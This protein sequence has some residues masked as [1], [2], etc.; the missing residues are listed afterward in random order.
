MDKRSWSAAEKA[1]LTRDLHK[2]ASSLHQVF[3]Q[4]RARGDVG[5][6]KRL[7]ALQ[8]A[9][10]KEI[11]ELNGGPLKMSGAELVGAM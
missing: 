11:V 10:A 1:L 4:V 3:A 7:Q 6:A 8:Q 2:A 9:V 5:H